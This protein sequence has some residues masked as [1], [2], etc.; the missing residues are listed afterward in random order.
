MTPLQKKKEFIDLFIDRER[1][2]RSEGVFEGLFIGVMLGLFF[3]CFFL[4]YFVHV[5]L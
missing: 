1:I 3:S 5:I 2:A 4:W